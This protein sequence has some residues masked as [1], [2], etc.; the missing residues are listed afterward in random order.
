MNRNVMFGSLRQDIFM[1]LAGEISSQSFTE[2]FTKYAKRF[3]ENVRASRQLSP[4]K[5]G[6]N[7]SSTTASEDMLTNI[8]ITNELR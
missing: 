2:K 6:I 3:T 1:V 8:L 5:I 7:R 4:E